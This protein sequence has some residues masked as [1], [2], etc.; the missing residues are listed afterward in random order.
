[1][2]ASNYY[3][4]KAT[5]KKKGFTLSWKKVS[6]A[7]GYKLQIS[8]KK[9]FKGAKTYTINKSKKK[10]TLSKLKGKTKYYIRIC[11]YKTYKGEDGK[12]TKVYG[13]YVSVSKK[14]K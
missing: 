11:A 3:K 7:S 14:T 9:N 6:G 1:M 12:T 10:Y 2:I 13:K 8:T 5:A 4:F